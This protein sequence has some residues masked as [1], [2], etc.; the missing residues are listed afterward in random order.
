[1]PSWG[2]SHLL[3]L[4]KCPSHMWQKQVTL[5]R[6]PTGTRVHYPHFPSKWVKSSRGQDVG[7][8]CLTREKF[9][10]LLA[11]LDLDLASQEKERLEEKQ[12]EAR[13]E[14]AKEDAEW[15]TR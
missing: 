6:W 8:A 13:K 14:R 3:V 2:A 4:E 10:C 9:K 12:R 5:N 15:R 11:C 1:M 7:L